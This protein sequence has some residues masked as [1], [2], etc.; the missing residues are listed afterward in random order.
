M[1]SLIIPEDRMT[2]VSA[3]T[4]SVGLADVEVLGAGLQALKASTVAIQVSCSFINLSFPLYFFDL[5]Y[6][7]GCLLYHELWKIKKE[8]S[9]F[10]EVE[11]GKKNKK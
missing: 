10:N 7:M 9:S 11:L 2:G 8:L 4:E 5:L 3:T 1:F 6:V